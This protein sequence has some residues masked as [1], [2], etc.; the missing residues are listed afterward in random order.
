MSVCLCLE[1]RSPSHN[2][3]EFYSRELLLQRTSQLQELSP[4]PWIEPLG[5][6]LFQ[7]QHQVKR[8]EGTHYQVWDWSA[9]FRLTANASQSTAQ[10]R[11]LVSLQINETMSFSGVLICNRHVVENLRFPLYI[12]K[13]GNLQVRFQLTVWTQCLIMQ[14]NQNFTIKKIFLLWF[15]ISRLNFGQYMVSR[16][17]WK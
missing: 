7:K 12:L 15:R 17:F 2:T 4:S 11:V 14:S 5:F 10:K 8:F 6:L 9:F 13:E 3:R 1:F 16:Q